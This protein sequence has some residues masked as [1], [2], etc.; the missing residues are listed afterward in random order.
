MKH[1]KSNFFKE[2][3]KTQKLMHSIKEK[4]NSELNK[5]S[6]TIQ[7]VRI[8]D[9]TI[10]GIQ[11]SFQQINDVSKTMAN[12]F[13]QISKLLAQQNPVFI[14]EDWYLSEFYYRKLMI[15]EMLSLIHI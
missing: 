11:K 15:I 1:N 12:V 3:L 5:V 8:P 9:T 10:T 7:N 2:F 6:S 14:E 13:E 4:W